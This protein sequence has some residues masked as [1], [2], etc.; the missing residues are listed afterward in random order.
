MREIARRAAD[1]GVDMVLAES[2]RE[3]AEH[4]AGRGWIDEGALEGIETDAERDEEEG[5][6]LERLFG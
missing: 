1:H 5:G 6:L 3:T 4:A 2:T